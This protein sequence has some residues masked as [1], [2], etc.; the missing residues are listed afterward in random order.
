MGFE[1]KFGAGGDG[2]ARGRAFSGNGLIWFNLTQKRKGG[3]GLYLRL[4]GNEPGDLAAGRTPHFLWGGGAPP[5]LPIL[6]GGG[7][8]AEGR[9]RDGGFK[10]F[11]LV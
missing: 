1:G 5:A 6:R 11:D 7:S 4:I 9:W 3:L 2:C 8:G 10:W